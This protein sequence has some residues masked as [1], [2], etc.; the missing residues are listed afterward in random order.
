MKKTNTLRVILTLAVATTGVL[1]LAG[2]SS[3]EKTP[4]D[5]AAGFAVALKKQDAS[6]LCDHAA[7]GGKAV[8]GDKDRTALCKTVLAPKIMSGMGGNAALKS[9][10]VTV[11]EKGTT[12]TATVTGL[13]S[14]LTLKKIDGSWLIVIA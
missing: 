2:C 3:A 1:G 14:A 11:K 7:I 13:S 10:K 12:A 9:P 4:S 8:A 5:T 6:S